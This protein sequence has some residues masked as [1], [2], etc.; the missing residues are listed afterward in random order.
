MSQSLKN[1]NFRKKGKHSV[2]SSNKGSI[3]KPD[4]KPRTSV[5]SWQNLAQ[6]KPEA[7]LGRVSLRVVIYLL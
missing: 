3:V 6:A 4:S 1:Y 2:L 5:G 7:Y